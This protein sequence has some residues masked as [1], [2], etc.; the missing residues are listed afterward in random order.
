MIRTAIAE[1]AEPLAV[2]RAASIS[3]ARAFRLHDRGLVAPGWR[4]DLAIIDGLETCRVSQVIAAGRIVDDALFAAR[5]PCAAGGLRQR[6]AAQV[7]A[8]GLPRSPGIGK[9]LP[10][11]GV[12]PGKI[13]TEHLVLDFRSAAARSSAIRHRMRSRWRWWSA[14]ASMAISGGASSMASG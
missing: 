5:P 1:G 10:V 8:G 4:A 11:I 3:A 12:L 9:A 2:Y 13:I 6:Q 14:M 7:A